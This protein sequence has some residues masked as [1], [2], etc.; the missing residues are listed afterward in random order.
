MDSILMS[1]V[2][3]PMDS[4]TGR[5]VLRMDDAWRWVLATGRGSLALA[6]CGILERASSGMRTVLISCTS[7]AVVPVCADGTVDEPCWLTV[8]EAPPG[9]VGKARKGELLCGY[10]LESDGG[11][12]GMVIQM[13]CDRGPG[14]K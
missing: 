13:L 11:Q 10:A 2:V 14:R 12:A 6:V 4:V 5:Q 9:A 3:S 8:S 7:G 1:I